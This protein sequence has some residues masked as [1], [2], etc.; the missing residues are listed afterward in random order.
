[1]ILQVVALAVMAVGLIAALWL[2]ISGARG[3]S[4][5]LGILGVVLLSLG[6]FSRFAYQW[7][8][9]RY[10][11]AV[12]DATIITALAVEIAVGGLLL[13]IGLLLV[14]RAVVVAGR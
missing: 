2:L 10:L 6:V 3:T 12:D 7:L 14:M 13:G 9:Q 4:R 8:A 5:V 11:G 1:M